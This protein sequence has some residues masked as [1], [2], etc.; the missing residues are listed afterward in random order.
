MTRPAAEHNS[1]LASEILMKHW[2]LGERPLRTDLGVSRATWRVGQEYWLSQSE[3]G[4]SPELIRRAE[5]LRRLGYF[6]RDRGL[7]ISVPEIV[8]GF[9]GEL[10]LNDRGYGWSLTRHIKGFH[11]ES[12]IPEVYSALVE[13]LA[14]FHRALRLFWENHPND[15][16]QGISAKTRQHIKRLGLG[17]LVP[18]T[19]YAKEEQVLACAAKWLLP[20]LDRFE[21]L[22]RQLIH[23]DWTPQNVLFGSQD[24]DSRLIAVLD[25]EEIGIDPVHVDVASIC[26]T[27]LMWSGLD[28]PEQRIREVLRDYERFS[29]NYLELEDV[30]TAMLAHWFCHYWNWRDRIESGG[31]RQDARERLC[32]RIASVLEY[33]KGGRFP[34]VEDIRGIRARF[35]SS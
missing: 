7:P 15:V 17:A 1:V 13:G 33:L 31:F 23:G 28:R 21:Q 34:D 18:F 27:L 25:F 14:Q 11:P 8:P 4:R 20:R 19:K 29:E 30:H 26:S 35:E 3:E 16:A 10:V 2:R 9:S 6:L 12:S 32:L 5:V 22:P 24:Q